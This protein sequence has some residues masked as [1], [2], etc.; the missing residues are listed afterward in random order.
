MSGAGGGGSGGQCAGAGTCS[1]HIGEHCESSCDCCCRS[2]DMETWPTCNLNPDFSI[3]KADGICHRETCGTNR[4]MFQPPSLC[5]DDTDCCSPWKCDEVPGFENKR[6]CS[7]AGW[8]CQSGASCC[9]GLVCVPSMGPFAR[10]C[11]ACLPLGG[12]CDAGY[13]CCS[14]GCST[15]NGF[16]QCCV[17]AGRGGCSSPF[18]CCGAASCNDGACCFQSGRGPCQSNT[19]C[20]SGTCNAGVCL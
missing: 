12:S 18:D 14:G 8:S 2:Q 9:D 1:A 13:Q 15:N 3:C 19:E 16:G 6:C 10:V 11:G 20:C 4:G 7:A 17:R 5:A